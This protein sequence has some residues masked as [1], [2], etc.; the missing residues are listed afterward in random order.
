M[1]NCGVEDILIETGLCKQGTANQSFGS[2]GDYYQ[3]IHAHKILWEAM[4]KLHM[5]AFE[6]VVSGKKLVCTIQ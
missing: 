1:R 6:K 3:S 4:V 5:D 2:A